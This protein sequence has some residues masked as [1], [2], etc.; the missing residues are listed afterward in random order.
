MCTAIVSL[1]LVIVKSYSIQPVQN[2]IGIVEELTN[3]IVDS[4]KRFEIFKSKVKKHCPNLNSDI[5][6]KLCT[7]T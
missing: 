1:N 7:I 4:P 2:T 5:S 3:F 6:L